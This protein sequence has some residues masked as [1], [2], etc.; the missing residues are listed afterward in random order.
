MDRWKHEDPCA[1]VDELARSLRPGLWLNLLVR[2]VAAAVRFQSDILGSE[3]IYQDESF[4]I[5]H[6]GESFWMLHADSTY[7]EHAMKGLLENPGGRGIGCEI[8]L[9]DCDPDQ[10]EQRAHA[11]EFT[12]LAAANDRPHG[13]REAYLVD[14][15]GYVWV[16][17]VAIG[18][19][20]VAASG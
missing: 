5:M 11:G 18:E 13:L 20:V 6:F 17:S 3:V 8:R 2:D 19:P 7:A 1:L 4:A 10:A 9:H 12:V 15:D 14:Q 16:P